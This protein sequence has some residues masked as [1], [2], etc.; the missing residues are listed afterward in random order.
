MCEVEHIKFLRNTGS[1]TA[2]ISLAV[3]FLRSEHR[4]FL[5]EIYRHSMTLKSLLVPLKIVSYLIKI[6]FV[7]DLGPV[8][9]LIL[10]P[11]IT[12]FYFSSL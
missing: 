5:T 1:S 11:C 12:V 4:T 8:T 7:I 2:V 6:S 10:V 3:K 9:R